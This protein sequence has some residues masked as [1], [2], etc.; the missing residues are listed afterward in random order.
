VRTSHILVVDDDPYIRHLV[1]VIL[2]RHAYT[3]TTASDGRGA[4][5]ALA[6]S[7]VDAIL[8]DA[9]M[10]TLDG[11][12]FVAA[13]NQRSVRLPI[14]VM[15]GF[16]GTGAWASSIEAVGYLTKPFTMSDLLSSIEKALDRG[17]IRSSDDP[18]SDRPAHSG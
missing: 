16:E 8:L 17:S 13:L 10:P 4:L 15:S 12:G 14:I 3:V 18:T 7:P 2:E 1:T 6:T 9:R 5:A 11:P